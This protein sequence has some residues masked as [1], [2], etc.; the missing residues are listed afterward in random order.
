M[1][2]RYHFLY[3]RSIMVGFPPPFVCTC[4]LVVS[5]SLETVA[6]PSIIGLVSIIGETLRLL[7]MAC[8]SWSA[9]SPALIVAVTASF[10]ESY[11][12]TL[13]DDRWC[14]II[15]GDWRTAADRL[16]AL[17]IALAKSPPI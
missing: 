13:I 8:S 9:K 2:W 15:F 4:D 16:N 10:A 7:S 5:L 17:S 14:S 1:T 6:V 3:L 11:S 12:Q